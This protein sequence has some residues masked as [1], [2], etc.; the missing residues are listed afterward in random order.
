MGITKDGDS[1]ESALEKLVPCARIN[2]D[3]SWRAA[4]KGDMIVKFGGHEYYV[5]VKKSTLNQSRV[6]KYIAIVARDPSVDYWIVIPPHEA[7]KM[8]YG[9]KGQHAIN[10]FECMS[11]GKATAKKFTKFRCT[12]ED[13]ESRIKQGIRESISKE[14]TK[15]KNLANEIAKQAVELAASHQSKLSLLLSE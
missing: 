10:A 1:T 12:P 2:P 4:S 8:A 6:F 15:Y 7:L 14:N 11:L 5:E 3:K 9:R 13:L